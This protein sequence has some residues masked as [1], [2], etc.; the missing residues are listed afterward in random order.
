MA[1]RILNDEEISLLTDEQ[2]QCYERELK[3]YVQRA[4]FVEKLTKLEETEFEPY[5]PDLTSISIPK[6]IR[7]TSFTVPEKKEFDLKPLQGTELPLDLIGK[8]KEKINV[9]E[10]IKSNSVITEYIS[11]DKDLFSKAA[12][13]K[14]Y[15]K[16]QYIVS[17]FSKPVLPDMAFT[18]LGNVL[19]KNVQITMPVKLNQQHFAAL[20]KNKVILSKAVMPK[21]KIRD[22]IK[23]GA[24]KLD[25]D[26]NSKPKPILKSFKKPVWVITDFPEIQGI[27][28]NMPIFQL[29]EK[30]TPQIAINIRSDIKI[31]SFNMPD[32]TVSYSPQISIV[33]VNIGSFSPLINTKLDIEFETVPDI[34]VK[35]FEKPEFERIKLPEIHKVEMNRYKFHAPEKNKLKLANAVKTSVNIKT[36][37]QP[38]SVKVKLPKLQKVNINIPAFVKLQKIEPKLDTQVKTFKPIIN[39]KKSENLRPE[40][41]DI[42]ICKGFKTETDA[43]D[44]LSMLNKETAL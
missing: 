5:K 22:F 35:S 4:A 9:S 24:V 16:K 32:T 41:P 37:E 38:H 34:K 15:E 33:D 28:V 3:I 13:F 23:P 11:I 2:R 21:I 18:K 36:F 25:F 42:K 7:L 19:L 20:E 39:F 14:P 43:Q 10:L 29:P 40:L 6:E 30:N 31:G 1:F 44:I 27:N 26:V 8:A 17:K 12:H